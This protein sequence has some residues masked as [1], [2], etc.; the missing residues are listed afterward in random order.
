[1][2]NGSREDNDETIAST[3]GSTQL[4]CMS[5]S[6]VIINVCCFKHIFLSPYIYS[7]CCP[8]LYLFFFKVSLRRC[9]EKI[10]I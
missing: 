10:R 1:M 6:I 2:I 3:K 8:I 7:A 4:T 9:Q 5:L